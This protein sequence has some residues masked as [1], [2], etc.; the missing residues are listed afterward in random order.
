MFH[1]SL[2][3]RTAND[4]AHENIFRKI[5]CSE[6]SASEA[7]RLRRSPCCLEVVHAA[8]QRH[9]AGSVSRLPGAEQ[10]PCVRRGRPWR[11]E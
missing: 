7:H 8:L 10:A 4:S 6:D 1:S 11:A 9:A 5:S 2:M 3:E